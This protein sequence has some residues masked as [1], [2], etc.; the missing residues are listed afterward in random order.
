MAAEPTPVQILPARPPERS[1]FPNYTQLRTR[2]PIRA[3]R[4]A[5]VATLATGLA[6]CVVLFVAPSTGLKLFWGL[7]VP[8]LPIVWLT[9]PGLWRNLCPLATSNQV[10]R[11][12]GF[13]KGAAAPASMTRFAYVFGIA[14]LLVLVPARKV[15]FNRSGPATAVLLLVVLGLAFLGGY[16]LKGKSG[17]C[18]TICPLLPVQRLYGETPF[19]LVRNSHC[20]PCVGCAK[21][22]YDFN[23]RVAKLA[24]LDDDDPRYAGPRRFFAGAYVGLVLGFFSMPSVPTQ[25]TMW[26]YGRIALYVAVCVGT[27]SLLETFLGVSAHKLTALFAA[28]GLNAFYWY[29]VPVLV[30]T[31]GG[32][33]TGTGR[34]VAV[35]FGR[36]AVAAVTIPWLVRTFAK[37]E[38]FLAATSGA[39]SVTEAALAALQARDD[40]EPAVRFDPDGP[41]VVVTTGT[42][43]LDVIE[44]AGLA[45]EAGCRLGVCG[46]D[47]VSVLD[48]AAALSPVTRDERSTLDRL[49][50]AEGTR[51]A[52]QA[53]V[54]G[55]CVVALTPERPTRAPPPAAAES[56]ATFT[57]D[58]TVRRL[59]IIG[60]GIA[61][62][63]A[64]D[65][66]RRLHP[67]C[68]I[69]LVG[70]EPHRLY[71]RMAI[72]R[73]IHGR[74]AMQGLYLLPDDW[75]DTHDVTS[76]LNTMA[77]SIDR[78][79]RTVTLATGESL[80]YD[81]VVLAPGSR[82]VTPDIPGIG[83]RG[84]FTVRDADDA[85]AIR[86]YA[87]RN[88]V[89]S[90]VV[91]GGG[92]LGLESAF[93]LHRLGL[94]TT[95]VQRDPR[96]MNR[97]LDEPAARL[98]ERYL[99]ALGIT[100][101]LD[102]TVVELTG[103]DHVEGAALA[104]GRTV[105]CGLFLACAGVVPNVELARA[106]G[107]RVNRGVI[108]D[109]SMQTSDPLI[110]AAGD[111][112]ELEGEVAGLW[113][114]SARQGEVAAVNAVGGTAVFAA[115]PATT[116]L[117][118]SGIDIASVGRVDGTEPG[119]T[120]IA[121][122]DADEGTYRRLVLHGGRVVGAI[123]VGRPL[124]L[125][126]VQQAVGEGRDVSP[127][128]DELRAGDWSSLS[129]E[130]AAAGV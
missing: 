101:V 37:E 76:W 35:W 5:R 28:A 57:P 26:V 18:S 59:V 96:L 112:V 100:V 89:V 30:D 123:L 52:C 8:T 66:A 51:L 34:E 81:R 29:S 99:E 118:V 31:L 117:K 4:V 60:N 108:V 93:A 61:G 2:V 116:L 55:S 73:L 53:R 10:P 120:A 43:L 97:Q 129:A 92:L 75:H 67:D 102:A 42:P 40:G 121:L 14:A 84:S 126:W 111:V 46:A 17:W 7:L 13:T 125:P 58:P 72:P 45:I 70:G 77:R 41:D 63:T 127:V 115:E 56:G 90:A 74:A 12:L 25:S 107:L 65:H 54:H 91:A 94:E 87:Q 1:T 69:H 86:A 11:V 48:G 122:E 104:D 106:A 32:S 16:L 79:Q 15:L 88:G 95:V 9:L 80:P 68:E 64:A 49:G 103:G 27:Y 98:L 20:E 33:P 47:P 110:Y 62:S 105:P 50:L 85:I 3:W 124:E 38:P 113:P 78:D 21:N 83:L 119:D 44:S 36:A 6:L 109:A 23:P 114:P 82:G 71:N 128:L 39:A 24:D 22:C 130:T 19:L